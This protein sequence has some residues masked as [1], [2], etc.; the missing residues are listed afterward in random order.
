[1]IYFISKIKIINNVISIINQ[2]MAVKNS[3][4]QLLDL[5]GYRNDYVA[6]KIGMSASS[7][8]VKKQRKSWTDEDVKSI[9]EVITKPNEDLEDYIMLEIMRE[10]ENEET[11]T[12]D[13]YN[14][15]KSKWK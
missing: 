14:K 1:M 12:I 15:L 8:A 3:I 13:D 11:L 6:K 10:R 4:P 2:Y 5:S 9:I 7:F